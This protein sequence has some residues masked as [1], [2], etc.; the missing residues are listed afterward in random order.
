MRADAEE[1]VLD[2]CIVDRLLPFHRGVDLTTT[3]KTLAEENRKRRHN[4]Q[5]VLWIGLVGGA[6]LLLAEIWFAIRDR[7][8]PDLG[9]LAGPFVLLTATA[10]FTR[11]HKDAL[12]QVE[13]WANRESAGF[14]LE[15]YAT[16]DE[17]DVREVGTRALP[18]ALAEIDSADD[19][20]DYQRGLLYRV[21]S[22]RNDVPVVSAAIA[23]IRRTAGPE[24]IP[25]LEAFHRK[26][27]RHRKAEWQRLGQQALM[28]LPEIRIRT[29]RRI[30]E[31]KLQ[32]A[33]DATAVNEVRLGFDETQD[34]AHTRLQ[35]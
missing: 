19:L 18:I 17:K 7:K 11:P 12:K 2:G 33:Q 3:M 24:A 23:C 9:G 26:T 13:A 4:R 5:T 30:I 6:F 15:A 27:E 8:A 28:V 31:R 21:V 1:K 35:G 16:T 14:L 25:Y 22:T 10:A 32:A 34:E 20:D 29:A